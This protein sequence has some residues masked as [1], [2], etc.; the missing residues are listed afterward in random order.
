M[1]GTSPAKTGEA[2]IDDATEKCGPSALIGPAIHGTADPRAGIESLSMM[3]CTAC[4]GNR[5]AVVMD[6]FSTRR[7]MLVVP[8]MVWCVGGGENGAVVMIQ[9]D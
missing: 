1:A 4:G 8:S 2:L 6:K 9:D 3:P 5:E 7:K